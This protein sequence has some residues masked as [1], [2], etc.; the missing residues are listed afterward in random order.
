MCAVFIKA[1]SIISSCVKTQEM[2]LHTFFQQIAPNFRISVFREDKFV[3]KISSIN[4]INRIFSLKYLRTV[5]IKLELNQS[6]GIGEACG[7]RRLRRRFGSRIV[8]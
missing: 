2:L 7:V 5:Q 8:Q 1:S 4:R 6:L 3:G